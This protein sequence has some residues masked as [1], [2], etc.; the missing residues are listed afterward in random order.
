MSLQ[1]HSKGDI[2]AE[3]RFSLYSS[4]STYSKA[5]I[6][7]KDDSD[8]QQRY[9]SGGKHNI[10]IQPARLEEIG[11]FDERELLFVSVISS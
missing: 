9:G 2:L 3:A 1:L 8:V 11:S 10:L 4:H 5:I 6:I 7:A